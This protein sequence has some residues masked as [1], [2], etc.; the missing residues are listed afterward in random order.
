[1]STLYLI[2]PGEKCAPTAPADLRDTSPACR[3]VGVN[4]VAQARPGLVLRKV[5]EERTT[6]D[7][8]HVAAA[9]AHSFAYGVQEGSEYLVTVLQHPPGQSCVLDAPGPRVMGASDAT[10]E[11][12]CTDQLYT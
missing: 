4:V 3:A 9:G 8:L 5:A 1:E 10:V 11:V 12:T 6:P 2:E 7:D